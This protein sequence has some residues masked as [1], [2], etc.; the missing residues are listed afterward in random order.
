[1]NNFV[2]GDKVRIRPGSHCSLQ[3]ANLMAVEFKVT[4]VHLSDTIMI[5]VVYESD[6]GQHSICIANDQ[7]EHA[8]EERRMWAKLQDGENT[9]TI[10]K[11]HKE[12][13]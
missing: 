12:T 13:L 8:T 6:G 1:M 11:R 2:K 10:L 3:Y 7:L 9:I 4:A 5:N